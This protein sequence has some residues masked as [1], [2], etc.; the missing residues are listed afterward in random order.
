MNIAFGM[1]GG[2]EIWII[3]LIA[4]LLFGHRIPGLARSLGAG[5]VEFKKGLRSGDKENQNLPPP[6]PHGSG[7]ATVAGQREPKAP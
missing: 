4:L 3:L 1:P 7:D 5:I 2:W 6:G